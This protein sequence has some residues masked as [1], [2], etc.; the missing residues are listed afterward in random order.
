[1]SYLK[2]INS[3][4]E[5]LIISYNWILRQEFKYLLD[6]LK[7]LKH[8]TVFPTYGAETKILED[9]TNSK[10]QLKSF[11]FGQHQKG[12]VKKL[13][14]ATILTFLK[15]QN[16]E[17]EELDMTDWIS[18]LNV[19]DK[20]DVFEQ[21]KNCKKLKKLKIHCLDVEGYRN[22]QSSMHRFWSVLSE[23]LPK[24]SITDL[25]I[26]FSGM[27][28][29]VYNQAWFSWL[30]DIPVDVKIRFKDLQVL[31]F[32]MEDRPM[33]T[34]LF[35]QVVEMDSLKLISGSFN[36]GWMIESDWRNLEKLSMNVT[37]LPDPDYDHLGID[38]QSSKWSIP[39]PMLKEATLNVGEHHFLYSSFVAIILGSKHL[40][41]LNITFKDQNSIS[42]FNEFDFE[43]RLQTVKN[44]KLKMLSLTCNVWQQPMP[45]KSLLQFVDKC[46]NLMQIN[47][48]LKPEQMR[49]FIDKG[50]TII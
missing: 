7:N 6:H 1:M 48:D 23:N 15:T 9:I 25:T 10:C 32:D 44:F 22:D 28:E 37:F 26:D 16:E 11:K 24:T 12:T 40:E 14:K 4:L 30:Q 45:F 49:F 35:K 34:G 33:P 17:L 39:F 43:N 13:D 42:R 27:D 2:G 46:P 41:N 50:F 38:P 3:L 19:D 21:L 8:L 31:Y 18:K 20:K 47:F 29:I 5:D 36:P